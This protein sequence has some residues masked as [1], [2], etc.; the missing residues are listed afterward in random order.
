MKAKIL[1][2]LVVGLMAGPAHA[3]MIVTINQVGT[4]VVMSATGTVNLADLTFFSNQSS[5]GPGM[6]SRDGVFRVG[7]SGP[8]DMYTG[9]IA[10]FFGSSVGF[11]AA[12]SGTGD[13][14][15]FV[16]GPFVV[17]DNYVSGAALSGTAT[18]ANTTFAMLGIAAGTFTSSWGTGANA[19]SLTLQIGPIS[20]PEPGTLA[21]LGLGLAGLGLSRR[22]KA[23]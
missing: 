21:L 16:A 13:L 18:F 1:G 11:T 19:D 7:A 2:L 14:F 23:N 12:S 20:V 10:P 4:D 6:N 8:A 9:V 17:P 3:V 15:G 5:L 22:R